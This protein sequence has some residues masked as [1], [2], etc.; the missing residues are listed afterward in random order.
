[1]A[2]VDDDTSSI[3][4]DDGES[5]AELSEDSLEGSENVDTELY[6]DEWDEELYTSDFDKSEYE[7]ELFT[8]VYTDKNGVEHIYKEDTEVHYNENG[9]PVD[10]V[11]V[12]ADESYIV[13]SDDYNETGEWSIDWESYAVNA[14]DDGF[15]K[16]TPVTSET[17]TENTII[18]RYGSERGRNGT[19]VGTDYSELS[20]PYDP[21]SQEY[22][23]YRV[24][25]PVECKKGVAAQNFGQKGHG[26]QYLFKDTFAEM[27]NPN[28]PNRTL[29]RIR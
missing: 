27:A 29:E 16:D 8:N 10:E 4:S 17:L 9:E 20:L 22:H 14:D 3:G 2:D 11:P 18:A 23:E 15:D 12:V 1:M 6:E 19:D 24:I 21:E 7:E 25:S 5:T 28:N 26:T 13:R